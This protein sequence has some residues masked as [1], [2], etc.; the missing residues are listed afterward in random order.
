MTN[1]RKIEIWYLV[2]NEFETGN[3]AGI[4]SVISA[5]LCFGIIDEY[6]Y[7]FLHEPLAKYKPQ[8]T[9][10]EAYYFEPHLKEPRIELI[11]KIISDLKKAKEFKK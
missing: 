9:Y 7:G 10:N 8:K 5:F 4:C 2:L 1:K 3:Y 11:K 6:E